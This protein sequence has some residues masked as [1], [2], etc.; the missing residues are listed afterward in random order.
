MAKKTDEQLNPSQ[1][2][3]SAKDA[4]GKAPAAK[5]SAVPPAAEEASPAPPSS[6]GASPDGAS[7][8]RIS[9]STT[10]P[11]D[12]KKKPGRPGRLLAATAF[13]LAAAAI[14]AVG[15]LY[16][17]LIHLN[18]NAKLERDLAQANAERTALQRNLNDAQGQWNQALTDAAA[19]ILD[20]LQTTENGLLERLNQVAT[21]APP[22]ERDWKLAELEYLL[23]VANHRLLMERDVATALDLLRS[24]DDL[25]QGL[26]DMALHGVRSALASEILSLEQTRGAD[27]QGLYL[28]LEALKRQLADLALA[29]PQFAA[30][31]EAATVG[32]EGDGFW[33]ALADEFHSLLQ[34]RRIDAEIGPPLAPDAAR[35][36]DLN[37]R[38]MLEQAQLAA[39]KQDQAVFATSLDSARQWV[40]DHFDGA[41]LGVQAVSNALAELRRTDLKVA[42]PD[43]SASLE[44]L[45]RV[46]RGGANE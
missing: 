7:S 1:E 25:L 41:D 38:L 43:I 4:A 45:R 11:K 21:A 24:A 28:R 18:P 26:E 2:A 13:L 16:F 14:V 22:S 19:Q 34:F 39:L 40:G 3:P 20:R 17:I 36:L 15:Y 6:S 32:G 8:G 46:R 12:A 9:P 44:E 37:L 31:K 10:S 30:P 42:L 29:Q 23:L 5:L 35:Y 27:L 33:A